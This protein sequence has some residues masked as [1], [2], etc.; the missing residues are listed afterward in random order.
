MQRET[1]SVQRLRIN[2]KGEETYLDR[3]YKTAHSQIFFIICKEWLL[4]LLCL[5]PFFLSLI[6]LF[7]LC[8][9][10]C[11]FCYSFVII[12]FKFSD[13]NLSCNLFAFFQYFYFSVISFLPLFLIFSL[14]TIQYN[15][16]WFKQRFHNSCNWNKALIFLFFSLCFPFFFYPSF[17]ISL[18]LFLFDRPKWWCVLLWARY[19]HRH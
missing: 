16:S 1:P 6:I 5:P 18:T 8:F 14:F 13:F 10:L 19:I 15:A 7:I 2:T 11:Y 12:I 3:L 9:L 4:W 17:V